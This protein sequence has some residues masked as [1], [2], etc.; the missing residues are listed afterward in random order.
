MI[1]HLS[2]GKQKI[3]GYFFLAKHMDTDHPKVKESQNKSH[4]KSS[5]RNKGKLA[6]V[7]L[8]TVRLFFNYMLIT[9]ITIAIF[10]INNYNSYCNLVIITAI[11]KER[12]S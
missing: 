10:Y 3:T 5:E 12:E 6:Q 4:K 8:K 11:I 7:T 2:V 1:L 9:V